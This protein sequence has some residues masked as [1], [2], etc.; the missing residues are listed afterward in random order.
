MPTGT[1]WF[2]Y[3]TSTYEKEDELKSDYPDKS[4]RYTEHVI[5]WKGTKTLD[6]IETREDFDMASLSYYGVSGVGTWPTFCSPLTIRSH[7]PC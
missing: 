7:L 6:Y 5:A 3:Y 1:L 2:F 4:E